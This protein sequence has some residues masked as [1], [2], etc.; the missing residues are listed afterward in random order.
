M[1]DIV[2]QA[3]AKWPN[4]PAVFG[5]LALDRRGKWLIK[6]DAVSS[7]PIADF[8]GR[9]YLHDAEGRWYFQNGPQRVYVALN[10]APF[11]YRVVWETEPPAPL[12]MQTHTDRA[13]TRV[14]GAWIDDAG[15][16][17]IDT[18]HG[19]G[20]VDDRDL[21][22]LL[23]CFTDRHGKALT[24]EQAEAA[25]EKLQSGG[26]ARVFFTYANSTVPFAAIAAGDIPLHFGFVRQPAPPEGA[27]V[28]N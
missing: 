7:A 28:C 27:E 19:P 6:G 15:V 20:K 2:K 14:T 16:L 12:R 18:E 9:N 4:V 3:M 22:L 13:V 11:V 17:L 8:I 26:N 24:E 1:D 10:Y 21:D 23:P 5:W 25:L